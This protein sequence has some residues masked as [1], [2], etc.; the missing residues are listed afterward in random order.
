MESTSR[1]LLFFPPSGMETKILRFRK[2]ETRRN[3]VCREI[4]LNDHCKIRSESPRRADFRN[5]IIC[6]HLQFLFIYFFSLF[7]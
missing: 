2:K 7:S 4:R 1:R 5:S 3:E 6:F